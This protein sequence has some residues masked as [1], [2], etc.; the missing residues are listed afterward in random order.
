MIVSH[1]LRNTALILP[2]LVLLSGEAF[3]QDAP[4]EF[5]GAPWLS[6]TL[7]PT[8]HLVQI[9][10]GVATPG[11]HTEDTCT[12]EGRPTWLQSAGATFGEQF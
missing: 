11:F 2:V 4:A 12:P 6:L 5:P 8:D 7:G 3:A 1:P 9:R 10:N